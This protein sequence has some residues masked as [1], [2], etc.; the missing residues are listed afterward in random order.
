MKMPGRRA[1]ASSCLII[2]SSVLF[3]Q[4]KP[5][6]FD[7]LA[8]TLVLLN[9]V[10]FSGWAVGGADFEAD[11][12]QTIFDFRVIQSFQEALAEFLCNV[13][14]RSCRHPYSLPRIRFKARV[15][16]LFHS[17]NIWQVAQTLV[18]GNAQ[19]LDLA[20]FDIALERRVA[21]E[22]DV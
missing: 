15:A 22:G 2:F 13:I 11:I 7:E 19:G 1:R 16:R 12:V 14:R 8:P 18:A 4:G 5:G 6:V 3:S 10:A 20:G 9:G 17:R 21:Q